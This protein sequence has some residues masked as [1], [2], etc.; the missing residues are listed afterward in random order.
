MSEACG[1]ARGASTGCPT[2][3]PAGVGAGASFDTDLWTAVRELWANGN[4]AFALLHFGMEASAVSHQVGAVI[5][6]EARGLHNQGK[7][8]LYFLDPNINLLRDPRWGRAQEAPPAR[9]RSKKP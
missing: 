9:T 7:G 1:E 3:F 5:G 2:S 8:A 6:R 4:T